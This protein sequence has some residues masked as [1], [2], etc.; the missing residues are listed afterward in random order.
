M[1]WDIEIDAQGL[2]CPLPVLRLRQRLAVLAPGQVV[3]LIADDPMAAIDVPHF[4]VEGG[5]RMIAKTV[6][7]PANVFYVAKG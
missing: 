7:G 6:E 3:R 2:R 5:H 1:D 4:C